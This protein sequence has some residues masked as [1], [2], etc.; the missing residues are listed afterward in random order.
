MAM[1]AQA[2]VVPVAISGARD[3]MHKGS[4]VINPVSRSTSGSA[5]RSRPPA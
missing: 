5:S 4:F 2:P 3:A 1:K